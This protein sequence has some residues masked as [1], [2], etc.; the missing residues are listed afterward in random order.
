[1]SLVASDLELTVQRLVQRVSALEYRISRAALS[2]W[3]S[4]DAAAKASAGR[5][6]AYLV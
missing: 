2:Q 3:L 5:Y 1:M 6:S 4:P